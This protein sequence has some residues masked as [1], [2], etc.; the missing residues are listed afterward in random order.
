MII[1]FGCINFAELES[2]TIGVAI[3]R[4]TE[5][6]RPMVWKTR[7]YEVKPNIFHYTRT[8]GYDFLSNITPEYGF[9]QSWFG[10]N[11]K[12]MVLVNTYIND[13]PEGINGLGNGPF[14]DLALERCATVHD[15]K[16]LLDSTNL[17]GRKTKAV[18]GIM[19]S[20]GGA[21]I[22]EVN[23]HHYWMYDA[24]D[25]ITAPHG[26]IVRTN[27]TF[28]QGGNNGIERYKRS[29]AFIEDFFQGDS[30]GVRSIM[31]HQIRDIPDNLSA[32]GD[33][34]VPN[35]YVDCSRTICTPFSIAAV[36]FHGVK[37]G[38]PAFLTTMWGLLGNPL[39]SIAV[40][41]WPVGE[42]PALSSS[43]SDYSMYGAAQ[44]L[45]SMIF[46][47]DNPRLVHCDRALKMIT[48]MMPIEDSIYR[49]V[50]RKREEWRTRPPSKTEL[51]RIQAES[52]ERAFIALTYTVSYYA[53]WNPRPRKYTRE[54]RIDSLSDQG[55][56]NG[57]RSISVVLPSNYYGCQDSFRVL[58]FLD[59]ERVFDGCNSDSTRLGADRVHDRL[60]NDGLINPAILVA[61]HN[62]GNR[63]KE[64]TPTPG[65]CRIPG[66]ELDQFYHYWNKVIKPYIDHSFRTMKDPCCT[67][68]V[69]H[70]L[71]GLASFHLAYSHPD[72]FGLSACMSP[73]FWWDNDYPIRLTA[74]GAYHQP[75]TRFWIMSADTEDPAMWRN[76]RR[77]AQHL[78][79]QGW[80]EG[81]NL[82]YCHVYGGYHSRVSCRQQMEEMLHFLLWKNKP[83]PLDCAVKSIGSGSL[84][85]ADLESLGE[86]ANFLLELQYSDGYRCNAVSP[87]MEIM[88][89]SKA[90]IL[91]PL[92]GS[93]V[94]V[95]AG[96]TVLRMKHQDQNAAL[97][98][99]SYNVN[100]YPR[101]S[102]RRK[103]V[104]I[105]VDGDL[106]EWEPLSCHTLMPESGGNFK[107]DMTWDDHWFYLA[108]QVI[109]SGLVVNGTDPALRDGIMIY[110]DARPDPVRSLGRGLSK[111]V[112]FLVLTLSPGHTPSS[113]L[114]QT[115]TFYGKKLPSGTR[116]TA[117]TDRNGYAAEIAV[118]ISYLNERQGE[119]W[120]EVRLNIAQRD[121][122]PVDSTVRIHWWQPDWESRNNINASGTFQRQ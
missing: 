84:H 62:N 13:Y 56:F 25:S 93:I 7:D 16:L 4:A 70:S 79:N 5:D 40:P 108:I 88:D 53:H 55:L 71:G 15:F 22:F 87:V 100:E 91:D 37:P 47:H 18:F 83:R 12:G 65:I 45:K 64:L 99:R 42:P 1:I 20:I 110:L 34:S 57:M 118:P 21:A 96:W 114:L 122:S 11:E 24:N 17:T 6:G 69:G 107:F 81:D 73:S 78:L 51:I 92:S 121:V 49:M 33:P 105:K 39:A 72:R 58:Y 113:M 101:R 86:N 23:S 68:I 74:Q 109:D 26:Y 2:C 82:A 75:K 80:T 102:I 119:N 66:G 89:T 61:I 28:S 29:A 103:P 32:S 50:N 35:G 111:W 90:G 98:I 46:D 30:L 43:V 54:I 36:V 44:R 117:L 85:M 77:V 116:A 67:G 120:R 112:D 48:T 9:D 52:V 76:A 60:W 19:D 94:P 3:G 14:M 10:V 8:D 97:S 106:K 38:E 104:Q 41:Y 59:G 31:K 27:F 63:F 95:R 115:D